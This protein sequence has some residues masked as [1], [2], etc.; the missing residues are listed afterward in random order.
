MATM[1]PQNEVLSEPGSP[2]VGRGI[3]NKVAAYPDSGALAAVVA[4]ETSLTDRTT[5]WQAMGVWV[6]AS[7]PATAITY[8]QW[9][10]GTTGYWGWK[11]IP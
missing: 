2:A 4:L 8:A 11:S 9:L 5:M 10:S 6:G 3:Q 1:G 7:A